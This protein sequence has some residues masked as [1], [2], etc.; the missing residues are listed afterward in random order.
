MNNEGPICRSIRILIYNLATRKEHPER[1]WLN[2]LETLGIG[3]KRI[4]EL[5]DPN[6][7]SS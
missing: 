5:N 3:A 1:W 2:E 4:N 6:E 7:I